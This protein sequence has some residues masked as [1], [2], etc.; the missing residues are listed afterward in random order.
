MPGRI[1][2]PR[3]ELLDEGPIRAASAY[4]DRLRQLELLAALG[5]GRPVPGARQELRAVVGGSTRDAIRRP[6]YSSS[7]PA[8]A[9]GTIGAPVRSAMSAAPGRNGPSS[10]RRP[11]DRA[12]RHRRHLRDPVLAVQKERLAV[13]ANRFTAILYQAYI[14]ALLSYSFSYAFAFRLS[15]EVAEAEWDAEYGSAV[16]RQA[17]L[18]VTLLGVADSSAS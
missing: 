18:A 10:A 12:F 2:G 16:A 9:R 6:M 7:V 14:A 17:H 5:L 3:V 15:G 11:V 8:I 4:A 1:D 13:A